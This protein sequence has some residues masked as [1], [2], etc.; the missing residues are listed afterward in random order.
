MY[1]NDINSFVKNEKEL[2]AIRIYCQDIGMKFG[3][4]TCAMLI[5]K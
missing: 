2:K 1:K 3:N 4:E 5:I